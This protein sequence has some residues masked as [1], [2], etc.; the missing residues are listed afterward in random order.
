MPDKTM[1]LQAQ[2]APSQE[3]DKA[4]GAQRYK[5]SPTKFLV[6]SLRLLYLYV[7]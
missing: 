5:A 7:L 6:I 4:E 3:S 1:G 2:A